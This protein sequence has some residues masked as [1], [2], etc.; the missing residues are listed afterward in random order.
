M[1]L[2]KAAANIGEFALLQ[3][4]G[5]RASLPPEPCRISAIREP[6]VQVTMSWGASQ[7]VD[8]IRLTLRSEYQAP[9]QPAGI[10]L[11]PIS[12]PIRRK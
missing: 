5:D 7:M 9:S 8:T 12:L 11:G 1:T 2:S 3:G 6:L 4:E 10:Y